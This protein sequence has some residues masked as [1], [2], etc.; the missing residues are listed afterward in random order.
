[1]DSIQ[2]REKIEAQLPNVVDL[3]IEGIG[4]GD[5][6]ASCLRAGEL[7][8]S[9]YDLLLERECLENTGKIGYKDDGKGKP[10]DH[11]LAGTVEVE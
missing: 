9:V 3:A 10:R 7:L 4:H 2:L 8:V 6:A 11:H 5:S 1:M